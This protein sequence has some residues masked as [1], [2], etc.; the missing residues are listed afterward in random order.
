MQPLAHNFV[1]QNV[2]HEGKTVQKSSGV[3][4]CSIEK[5]KKT[6]ETQSASK[7]ET[8]LLPLCLSL[9]LSLSL[10]LGAAEWRRR[11]WTAAAPVSN[12]KIL[13][14]VRLPFLPSLSLSLS[15]SHNTELSKSH[16]SLEGWESCLK[17]TQATKQFFQCKKF[18]FQFDFFSYFPPKKGLDKRWMECSTVHSKKQIYKVSVP[19]VHI[20]RSPPILGGRRNKEKIHKEWNWNGLQL[21]VHR[22]LVF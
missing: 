4:F 14:D 12:F 20:L 3:L 11:R 16:R 8:M 2:E 9:S 10:S 21:T 5:E 18:K 7:V 13:I 22:S 1:D 6:A 19:R 15:V 17:K